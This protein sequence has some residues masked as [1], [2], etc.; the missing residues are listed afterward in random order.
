MR[1]SMG[2]FTRRNSQGA[3]ARFGAVLVLLV[4]VLVRGLIPA[5][6]MPGRLADGAPIVICTGAGTEVVHAK[7]APGEPQRS[8]H[9]D[10]C[11]FAGMAAAPTPPAQ[12]APQPLVFAVEAAATAT[13]LQEA[14]APRRHRPQ[15]ARA[16]PIRI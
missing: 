1:S 6:F 15:A 2:G 13:A 5:G 4:A 3:S 12:A 7:S 10:V 11:A 9:H 16:P 14:A 8:Q